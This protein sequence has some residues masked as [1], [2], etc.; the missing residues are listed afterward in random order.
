MSVHAVGPM[1]EQDWQAE[2]D[3]RTLTAMQ[4]L[5]AA[6]DRVRRAKELAA[7]K[8]QEAAAV[9]GSIRVPESGEHSI[10]AGYRKLG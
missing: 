9:A 4:K 6:P 5:K 2:D 10:R 1:S 8:A 3:L 7:R